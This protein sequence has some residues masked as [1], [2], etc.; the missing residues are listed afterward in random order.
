MVNSMGAQKM[1]GLVAAA[2]LSL[3]LSSL[4]RTQ[5]SPGGRLYTQGVAGQVAP[6]A[7]CH[8][9]RGEGSGAIPR[10][11]GLPTSYVADQ[12]SAYR[13]GKRPD[14]VMAPIAKPLEDRQIRALSDY[15]AGLSAP[16]LKAAPAAGESLAL[17]AQLVA[18]GKW[19]QGVPACRD[20]HGPALQGGG[21]ALPGLAGQPADYL[22]AQL[23]AF[24][25]GTRPGGPLGL[26][27]RVAAQLAPAEMKGA[28]EYAAS[29]RE[30]QRAEAPRG[31]K[32]AWTPHAQD[33][34]AFEPPPESALPRNPEDAAA[35]LLGERIFT[36]T[37][38]YAA[39]YTGNTL[40]CRNCHTDRGRNPVSSP[41]WAAVPQ[42]PKFRS[43]NHRVNS[44]AIRIEGCFRYSQNGTPPP[45]DSET[46]VA[47]MTYMNWLATG[48]PIGIK[49]KAAGYPP[50]A[51]PPSPPD[52]ERG[53]AVY[54]ADCALCHGDDG[55]GSVVAG[56]TVI[57][58]LWGPH[59]YNWG[60]GMHD[61]DKAAAFIA[62]NMPFGAPGML[63]PQQAWDV[64]AWVDSQPRPQDPR[65]T[66]S[67]QKTR[68]LFHKRHAAGYYGAEVD[69]RTL[70][71]PG[72]GEPPAN[73]GEPAD[74]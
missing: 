49:P 11:A 45:A 18:L 29:L 4:G 43:K 20:C 55:Q 23:E 9:A 48:L 66:G 53:R 58:P 74:H 8:G 61:P 35:I 39:K 60:A 36:D 27:A 28:A 24:K 16:Y 50:L 72:N 70:G 41:M 2:G 13:D 59:S 31:A 37:P 26:M 38:K 64:A 17:G 10:L 65:F 71:A 51:A 52:R 40:S 54:T 33:P 30:G 6:C 15:V 67:V 62:A 19:S 5:E 46:M 73:S 68:E 32:S 44:L 7:A 47:L 12:L 42:Y 1:L 14:A 3:A 57:P 21:S 63:T 22:L 56:A 25:A 69:G 34:D